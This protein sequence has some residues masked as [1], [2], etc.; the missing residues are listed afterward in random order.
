MLQWFFLSILFFKQNDINIFSLIF[1]LFILF[2]FFIVSWIVSLI[3]CFA[4][5]VYISKNNDSFFPEDISPL[6]FAR[7]YHFRKVLVVAEFFILYL[8]ARFT[9]RFFV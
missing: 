1:L 7:I 9:I 8:I 3:L 2:G 5:D 6:L 4:I